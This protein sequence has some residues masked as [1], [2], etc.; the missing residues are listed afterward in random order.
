M[1]VLSLLKYFVLREVER[2]FQN[3]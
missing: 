2:V 1:T 3:V